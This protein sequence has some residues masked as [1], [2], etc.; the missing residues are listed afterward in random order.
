MVETRSSQRSLVTP[1][2][3]NLIIGTLTAEM[4]PSYFKQLNTPMGRRG[5]PT[6][7]EIAVVRHFNN[8]R[9]ILYELL[10]GSSP[11]EIS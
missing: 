9:L 6:E 4:T 10:T 11:L 3:V 7:E 5:T 8:L 1:L 2:E